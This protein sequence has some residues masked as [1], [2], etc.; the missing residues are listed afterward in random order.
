MPPA[1]GRGGKGGEEEPAVQPNRGF[2]HHAWPRAFSIKGVD[3]EKEG[4][5]SSIGKRGRGG[6]KSKQSFERK[7]GERGGNQR[8][9]FG[10]GEEKERGRELSSPILSSSVGKG[11]KRKGR[12]ECQLTRSGR[13]N[14]RCLL[15]FY[16]QFSD[17]EVDLAKKQQRGKR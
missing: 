3:G 5:F 14:G 6:E 15:Q 10:L 17:G 4:G 1:G 7:K 9:N 12:K 16:Q 13:G 8:A 11:G 2:P